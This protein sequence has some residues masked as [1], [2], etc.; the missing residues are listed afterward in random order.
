MHGNRC[1]ITTMCTEWN[2]WNI[3]PGC[4]HNHLGVTKRSD[5]ELSF[6]LWKTVIFQDYIIF[7]MNVV[8]NWLP[9]SQNVMVCQECQAVALLEQLYDTQL[10]NIKGEEMSCVWLSSLVHFCI[11]L[12]YTHVH[13]C[14][15][16]W[17]LIS[18]TV[19][20]TSVESSSDRPDNYGYHHLHQH[21]QLH[22]IAISTLFNIRLFL[23]TFILANKLF[24]T[25]YHIGHEVIYR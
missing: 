9:T 18:V 4:Y 2:F 25:N 19:D 7:L 16:Y 6:L 13:K 14:F 5:L 24:P 11:D 15:I 1:T 21:E 12:S 10:S 8:K 23:S 3:L 20:L 22:T 17:L